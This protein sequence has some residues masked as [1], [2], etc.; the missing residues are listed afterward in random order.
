MQGATEAI[1]DAKVKLL[2]KVEPWK[3]KDT[4]L[5]QYKSNGEKPGYL[6][7]DTVP[8]NSTTETF[9]CV[10]FKINNKRWKGVKFVMKA[11]KALNK[12]G[13]EVRILFK[14]TMNTS[15]RFNGEALPRNELILRINYGEKISMRMNVKTPGL[16][17]G[18]MAA[19]M[20]LDYDEDLGDLKGTSAYTRLVLDVLRGNQANFVRADE[21][22]AAWKIVTPLLHKIEGEDEV[23]P[24][25]YEF[26]SHGPDEAY[27][28][29]KAM[30]FDI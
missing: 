12:V 28:M 10:K 9:A 17:T 19:S 22:E 14:D 3:L 29:I 11:G 16:T 25:I 7:D 2:R 20:V 21:V 4:V 27:N 18:A 8:N 5:G 26:G 23:I 15:A 30:G 6:D 1:R 13:T 24:T